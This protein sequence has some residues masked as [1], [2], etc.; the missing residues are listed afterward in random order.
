MP[1]VQEIT[2]AS[3]DCLTINVQRPSTASLTA[4]LPVVFWIFGGGFELGGTSTYDGTNFVSKSIDLN[5]P[6]IYVSVN[7][8][9]GGFGFLAGRELQSDGS[10]NLGLR[11]QRLGLQW[12]AENIAAFGGDPDR[13]TI[14]GES[15]GA[16]SVYDQLL[17][18]NG[19]NTYNG[20]PL[21]RGAILDSGS[22]VPTLDVASPKAQAVF[23]TVARNAGCDTSTDVLACLRALPYTQF[24]NSV[25][26]VPGI[27]SYRSLD[28]S[29]LPRFD[30]SDGKIRKTFVDV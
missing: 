11:D 30:P 12:V 6:V 7:Y 22:A 26:G 18:N 9:V 3:E 10:T 19:D 29:Y 8:R 20:K 5:A 21:F 28:L 17:I 2:G 27:F 25:N 4:P 13:V 1:I 23:D 16:I 15:A 14:W 24:L